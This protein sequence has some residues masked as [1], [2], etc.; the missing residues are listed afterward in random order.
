M[1]NSEKGKSFEFVHM[2]SGY[3]NFGGTNSFGIKDI[4]QLYVK[5]NNIYRE[6]DV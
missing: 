2:R 1:L 3:S 5:I 6:V 4:N